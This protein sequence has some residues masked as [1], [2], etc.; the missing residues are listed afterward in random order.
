MYARVKIIV[1][2]QINLRGVKLYKVMEV[3]GMRF[4]HQPEGRITENTMEGNSSTVD[5]W[6][7][8]DGEMINSDV[9]QADEPREYRNDKGDVVKLNLFNDVIDVLAKHSFC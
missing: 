9:R 5:E 6:N 7:R 1:L 8:N 3:C 2:Y 4:G